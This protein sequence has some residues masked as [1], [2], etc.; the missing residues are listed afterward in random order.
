MT[1]PTVALLA[2]TSVTAPCDFDGFRCL[3][4]LQRNVDSQLCADG[5]NHV[6]EG[7]FPESGVF[8][9]EP[10]HAPTGRAAKTKMP[11]SFVWALVDTAVP[12]FTAVTRAYGDMRAGRVV[13]VPD[14]VASVCAK[15]HRGKQRRTQQ[16]NSLESSS[17][18][19]SSG[20]THGPNRIHYL[21]NPTPLSSKDHDR[22][23]S[24]ALP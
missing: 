3:A 9:G 5:Q 8:R 11:A 7:C 1:L 16:S 20:R 2:L 21:A 14:T 19:T 13:T 23:H 12:V 24:P 10:V 18:T 17:Q 6:G 4:E 15:T 22:A